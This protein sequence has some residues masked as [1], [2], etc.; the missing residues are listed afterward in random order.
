MSISWQKIWLPIMERLAL[1][2][3]A[4]REGK[5]EEELLARLVREG[6]MRYFGA[7]EGHGTGRPASGDDEKVGT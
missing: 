6:V 1:A 2:D 5:S 7:S 4:E 3:M